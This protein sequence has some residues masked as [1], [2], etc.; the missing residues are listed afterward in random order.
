MSSNPDGTHNN[1]KVIH[2]WRYGADIVWD[3][4]P[5]GK[6]ICKA[7]MDLDPIGMIDRLKE[8]R[9]FNAHNYQNFLRTGIDLLYLKYGNEL[10]ALGIN[11]WMFKE[12]MLKRTVYVL[13]AKPDMIGFA[14]ELKYK[15]SGNRR[16]LGAL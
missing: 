16:N 13:S 1:G 9:M 12:L 8:H 14:N 2:T 7:S 11:Q 10:A 15:F 6:L 4:G 5:V 3:D